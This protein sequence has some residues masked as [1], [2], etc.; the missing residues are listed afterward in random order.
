MPPPAGKGARSGELRG[1][2]STRRRVRV[3]PDLANRSHS[4]SAN[5]VGRDRRRGADRGGPLSTLVPISA[6]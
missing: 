6:R 3:R 1:R 2:G 5:A 4:P